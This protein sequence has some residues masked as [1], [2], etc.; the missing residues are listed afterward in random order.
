[1]RNSLLT[2]G[3]VLQRANELP[4]RHAL[5]LKQENE[6]S[7]QTLAQVLEGCSENPSELWRPRAGSAPW[8]VCAPIPMRRAK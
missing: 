2:L 3:E 7:P 6:W 1:M 4:W 8:P 5:Y